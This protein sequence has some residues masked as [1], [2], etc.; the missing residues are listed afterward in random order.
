MGG[1][2]REVSL[3]CG[4]GV[5]KKGEKI[6]EIKPEDIGLVELGQFGPNK[7]INC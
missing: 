4:C 1:E 5:K 3:V 7:M 2:R 6:N